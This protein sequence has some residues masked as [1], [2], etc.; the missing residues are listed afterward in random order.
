MRRP[1]ALYPIVLALGAIVLAPWAG[2]QAQD[3]REEG[4]KEI[5]KCQTISKPGSYKLV[6]DLTFSAITGTCLTITASSVTIDL[7]GFTMTGNGPTTSAIVATPLSGQVLGGI[8]VR[9]GSISGF[10]IGV[11]LGS[12]DGSIVEGLRVFGSRPSFLGIAATGIVKGNTAVGIIGFPGDL[13]VGIGATGIVTGNYARGNRGVGLAI[14]PGST[15][16]GN[17]VSD[18]IQH[19]IS[20][21]CPSNLTDNTAVNNGTN[22]VLNGNGCHSED[23][24]AP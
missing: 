21:D 2:A 14:G 23:N 19:G 4:P 11:D 18:N 20:V 15:V 3:A 16:I 9:N 7:A 17:T 12:A 1:A 22:L 10:A 5:E 24:L 6:N 8:A 13:G